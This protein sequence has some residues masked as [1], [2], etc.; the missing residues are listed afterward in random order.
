MSLKS[1]AECA[2]TFWVMLGF[3]DTE[4]AMRSI[5]RERAASG[6]GSCVV[7]RKICHAAVLLVAAPLGGR[8]GLASTR[9]RD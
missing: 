2:N 5:V 8:F 6:V 3:A 4:S 9:V 1:L 7:C